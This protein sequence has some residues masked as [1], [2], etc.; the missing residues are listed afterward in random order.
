[1]PTTRADV[2]P[3]RTAVALAAP[4]AADGVANRDALA[5]AMEAERRQ[6]AQMFDDVD[7]TSGAQIATCRSTLCARCARSHL[8]IVTARVHGESFEAVF[9]WACVVFTL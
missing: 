9:S 6:L 7:A 4:S 2:R 1:M 5:A 8:A 3:T